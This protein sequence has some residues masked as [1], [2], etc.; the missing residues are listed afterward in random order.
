MRVRVIGGESGL[1][2]EHPSTGVARPEGSDLD[3]VPFQILKTYLAEADLVTW[4]CLIFLQMAKVLLG[5]SS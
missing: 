2:G 3:L 5:P 4:V 1:A